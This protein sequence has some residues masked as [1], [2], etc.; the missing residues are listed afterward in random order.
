VGQFAA[1]SDARQGCDSIASQKARGFARRAQISFDLAQDKPSHA[2]R[3][4]LGM[5]MANCTTTDDSVSAG[6]APVIHLCGSPHSYEYDDGEQ[7]HQHG[8]DKIQMRAYPSLFTSCELR[9]QLW[10]LFCFRRLAV[11]AK[12]SPF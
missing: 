4:R 10:L 2:E 9:K 8:A 11:Q 3:G 5:T 12:P 7:C 1:L 6:T